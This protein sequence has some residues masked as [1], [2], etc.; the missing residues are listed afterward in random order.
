MKL[1]NSNGSPNALR[2]RAVIHELNAPVEIVN[3]DIG[4][5]ENRTPEFLALNPNGKVPTFTDGDVV[6]WESRAINAY[7]AAKY[8]GA[9]LYPVDLA[10]RAQV[11]Q[12]SYWQ[13]IHL[14]PSMQRVAFERVQ[15]KAF[16]R[17]DP[18][19]AAIAADVKTTADL[20]PLLDAALAGKD[21]VT[22]QLSLADF[23]LATTFILRK[24]ARLG[25]EAHPNVTAWIERL[26]ARPSWEKAVA[27]MREM[28]KSRGIELG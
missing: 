19:E 13:S 5:R 7:L 24:A 4:K 21:W 6:I 12:W 28:N 17:G 2:S 18:E 14:G 11:D 1:Y 9:N 3:V 26:E 15:K 23:A 22:G 25:V 8:P 16:G 10:A 27:P 20:L